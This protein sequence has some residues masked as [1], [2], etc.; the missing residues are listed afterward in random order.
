MIPYTRDIRSR[1]KDW[2]IVLTFRQSLTGIFHYI[3]GVAQKL[4][5]AP[6][7]VID[8]EQRR[9]VRLLNML[10]IPILAMLLLMSSWSGTSD[11]FL[12]YVVTNM[13]VIGFIYLLNRSGRYLAA[14][15]TLTILVSASGFINFMLRNIYNAPTPEISLTRVVLAIIIAYLVL[16]LGWILALA[17][18]SLLG[19]IVIMLISPTAYLFLPVT[20][21]FTVITT[22]LMTIAALSRRRQMEQIEQQARQLAESEARFRSLL[23]AS[24]EAIVVLKDGAILDTNAAIETLLGYKPA[25]VVGSAL[26]D[27]V[28]PTYHRHV[29]TSY[30]INDGEPFEALLRHKGGAAL[31]VE[32]RGKAQVYKGETVRVIA[33]RD[34]TEL[35]NQEALTI[36][37]E[38]V[39]ALQKFIGN[40]SHDLRTPLTVINTSIY[41]INRLGQEPDRQHHQ[42][43][44]LREQAVHM[45][46]LLEDLISM[47][48]LDK[49]DT[50]DFK[51][52]F[53]NVSEPVKLAVTDQQKLAQRK[54]QTLSY[55]LDET[56]PEV[57]LDRDQFMLAL[58]HLIL[59]GLTYTGEGGSVVVETA[60][61]E[62][63]V[64]VRVRD[65]GVGIDPEDMPHIFEYFYRADPARGEEGGTGVGLVIA[66]K[67]VEA[68]GGRIAVESQPGQ[69]SVFTI[70]LPIPPDVVEKVSG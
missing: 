42:I 68:H 12:V 6:L 56:A 45:Q 47:S 16:P 26:L 49:A 43:D 51:F 62:R 7:I 23:E 40:L 15:L 28:E 48:R 21:Y 64:M 36:E 61:D 24:F 29:V 8:L 67:I 31:H 13:V 20:V 66:R 10:L 46:R 22:A 17:G 63:N 53:L 41:L 54:N 38:K 70:F 9:Q 58:K 3:D 14:A 50:S 37:R 2:L 44:V 55:Q 4:V 69:G 19:M 59:N 25:E 27:F 33:I 39:R 60:C 34:I 5:D 65:N 32:L 11:Q 18:G 35:K 52:H 57:L 30:E 1:P